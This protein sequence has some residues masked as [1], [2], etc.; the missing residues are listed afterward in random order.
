MHHR[1]TSGI[2]AVSIAVIVVSGTI[3]LGI[4]SRSTATPS[5]TSDTDMAGHHTQ[6]GPTSDPTS[7][8]GKPS[9]DFRL[10]DHS[11]KEYALADLKGKRVVLF[12]NE[13]LMCYPACWNQIA[14]LGDDERFTAEDIIALSV[15]T[16]SRN[17]WEKAIAKMP[18][19]ASATVVHDIGGVVSGQ[20]GMLTTKSSMHYGQLPGH[21]YVVIDAG[22]V[23]RHAYDDPMMA[24]HNDQLVEELKKI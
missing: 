13:G 4:L 2:I 24:I 20:F 19:L 11:G 18:E 22:G 23:I 10:T 6:N 1:N 17:E 15:V 5:D 21:S 8:V 16:D 9:P 3:A 12:F 14:A 7:F